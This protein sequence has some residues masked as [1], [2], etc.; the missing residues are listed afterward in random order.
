MLSSLQNIYKFSDKF[1]FRA[2]VEAQPV[3][4]PLFFFLY[5]LFVSMILVNFFLTIICEAFTAVRL[6]KMT[7][8]NDYEIVDYMVIRFKRFMNI[9]S[10]ASRR[11]NPTMTTY[12]SGETKTLTPFTLNHVILT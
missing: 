12:V 3:L 2:M 4:G 7:Q 10:P 5:S 9:G 1:D 6:D 11:P 8:S